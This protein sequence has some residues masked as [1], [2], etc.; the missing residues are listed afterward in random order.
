M[1]EV[2]GV[3]HLGLTVA[4]LGAAVGFYAG[5]GYRLADR[6]SLTGPDG[7]IGNGL[8]EVD[9]EVAFMSAPALTLE[10]VEFNPGGRVRPGEDTPGF[11]RVPTWSTPLSNRDPDGRPVIGLAPAAAPAVG[12]ATADPAAT[13]RLLTVLGFSQ[14]GGSHLL[15]GHGIEVELI[16]VRR[17]ATASRADDGGRVHLCCQVTDMDAACAHLASEGYDLISAPR[18]SGDLSWVFVR[19]PEGPGIELLHVGSD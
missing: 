16:D 14:V 8:N 1:Q 18:V 3:H 19:H 9:L 13:T 17:P 6:L 10:L 5:S 11:G 2:V 4:D 12:V 7:G 15:S